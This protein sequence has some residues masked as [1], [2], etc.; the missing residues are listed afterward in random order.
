VAPAWTH[1]VIT[2]I[3]LRTAVAVHLLGLG[4]VTVKGVSETTEESQMTL[5][6]FLPVFIASLAERHPFAFESRRLSIV[7]V[8]SAL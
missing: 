6:D 1:L 5:I 2:F 8:V 7:I 4:K 3:T